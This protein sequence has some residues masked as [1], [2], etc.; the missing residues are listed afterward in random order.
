VSE[1]NAITGGAELVIVAGKGGVGKTTVAAGLARYAANSGIDVLVIDVEGKRGIASAFGVLSLGYQEIELAAADPGQHLGRITGRTVTPD[2]ALVEWLGDHGLARLAKRM[3]STGLVDVIATATPGIRDLLVLA[4]VKQL[5]NEKSVGLVILDTPASGH[6]ISFLQSA[7]GLVD[8]VSS[9]PIR[10]QADDVLSLLT[11]ATR[12]QVLLVTLAEE[13]PVNEVRDTAFALEDRVGIALGPI[14]VN[15]LLS[16][17][18]TCEPR[19][20]ATQHLDVIRTLS[21]AED[22]YE[23]QRMQITRLETQLPLPQI[24]LPLLNAVSIGREQVSELT[25]SFSPTQRDLIQSDRTLKTP[26]RGVALDHTIEAI[27]DG[28]GSITSNGDVSAKASTA[29]GQALLRRQVILCCGPGG[30]GKTTTAAALALAAAQRGERAV[31][32]TIDP[33]K[34][35]ADALGLR[36]LTNQPTRVDA[37]DLPGELWAMML[38][39]KATFDDLVRANAPSAGQA[40]RILANP[41]YRNISSAM[42]GTQEYM[43]TEKLYELVHQPRD[44][45]GRALPPFDLVVVDTPPTRN[46]LDFVAAPERLTRLL[47]NTVFRALM[48]PARG[49]LRVMGLATQ[50]VLKGVGKV[51]GGEVLAD[52][53]AFFQAFEGMEEGFRKRAQ[54]VLKLLHNDAT[55]WVLVTGPTMEAVDEG[56]AFADA[57]SAKGIDLAAIIANRVE[58]HVSGLH[59][60][61]TDTTGEAIVQFLHGIDSRAAAHRHALEPLLSRNV[62][63][64]LVPQ[65]GIDVHERSALAMIAAAVYGIDVGIPLTKQK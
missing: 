57:L 12:T 3:V 64:V 11:D 7:R 51:I 4:K 21:N 1:L 26:W 59:H 48:A 50:A 54:N 25:S 36:A 20:G 16:E 58:P 23:S 37:A 62:P 52:A 41:F 14:V 38:D 6:A 24:H 34:R 28:V 9:G 42:G 5:V 18:P 8:A 27:V 32:V 55:A 13:T 10:R 19:L 40:D 46:A 39:T 35:L 30:V 29:V 22:R 33:A 2:D 47:D 56:T 60:A 53:V 45:D 65:L 31:V 63:Q 17:P 49:G 61:D 44:N 15:G 43:A